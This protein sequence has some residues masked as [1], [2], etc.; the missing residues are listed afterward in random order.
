MVLYCVVIE[1]Y[2]QGKASSIRDWYLAGDR[3]PLFLGRF[4]H[5][6]FTFTMDLGLHGVWNRGD[7]NF[8]VG[9]L[10]GD[11]IVVIEGDRG[12]V[13]DQRSRSFS[14][15]RNPRTTRLE[16]QPEALPEWVGNGF[17]RMPMPYEAFQPFVDEYY[18]ITASGTGGA[19]AA[20]GR[21]VTHRGTR[22]PN[23][24][25][26]SDGFAFIENSR[27]FVRSI[28]EVRVGKSP[29]TRIVPYAD[30]ED[31]TA[32]T[33]MMDCTN[34]LLTY[35][36]YSDG[37]RHFVGQGRKVTINGVT[38][39]FFGVDWNHLLTLDGTRQGA[40]FGNKSLFSN[41]GI[42][43]LYPLAL[44]RD[45]ADKS[46]CGL[47]VRGINGLS[48]D[49]YF[50]ADTRAY[51]VSGPVNIS[52]SGFPEPWESPNV[53]LWGDNWHF[54][55][56]IA[57]PISSCFYTMQNGVAVRPSLLDLIHFPYSSLN[58]RGLLNDQNSLPGT[59]GLNGTFDINL[60][61]QERTITLYAFDGQEEATYQ[62]KLQAL[63]QDPAV[64]LATVQVMAASGRTPG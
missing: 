7:G 58:T 21:F 59:F 10:T 34:P 46:V 39:Q 24:S 37:D 2:V 8:L 56:P 52:T 27:G 15:V 29:N 26:I 62:V 51:Y 64:D 44:D 3:P 4:E 55:F 20:G 32:Y 30:Y 41:T 11:A 5:F 47:A 13:T 42:G 48:G 61:R 38:T 22:L 18:P 16:P 6:F 45:Q 31:L 60:W 49:P 17:Y 1:P 53:E 19:E 28:K 50:N 12:G 36:T 9:I 33:R 43:H 57:Q 63:V 54:A 35:T 14:L 25:G 23:Y 40:G